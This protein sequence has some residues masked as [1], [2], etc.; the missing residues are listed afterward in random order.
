MRRRRP[1]LPGRAVTLELPLRT[2]RALTGRR[3]TRETLYRQSIELRRG[4]EVVL[5]LRARL[6][7]SGDTA[8]RP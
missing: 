5:R 7:R 6:S 8:P 2:L 3:G 4:G 1:S